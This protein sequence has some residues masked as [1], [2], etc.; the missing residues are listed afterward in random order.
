MGGTQSK[1]LI[2]LRG[3]PGSG[4][5][6]YAHGLTNDGRDGI[7]LSSDNYFIHGGVYKYNPSHLKDSHIWNQ[8]KAA[9]AMI[10]GERLI[11]IDNVN[12]RKWEARP[13]V[14]MAVNCGYKIEFREPPT[15]WRFNIDELMEHDDKNVPQKT[16]ER[17]LNEWE[18]DFTVQN[19]L[20]SRAPWERKPR[21]LNGGNEICAKV[22]RAYL[23]TTESDDDSDDYS[24]SSGL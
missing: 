1:R 23:Y 14:E 5:T 22:D 18:Y 13:Y 16:M 15:P 2:I 3:L 9:E 7:I 24:E 12:A 21:G 6:T 20:N 17:M 8:K 10:H 4:K 19:V 11:V